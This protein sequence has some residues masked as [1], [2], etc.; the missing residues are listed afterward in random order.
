MNS[1]RKIK[2]EAI[3]FPI[4]DAAVL[5]VATKIASQDTLELSS[6]DL[7]IV[8]ALRRAHPSAGESVEELGR[9]LAQMNQD[10]LQ[11]VVSNAKGILHEML[12]VE[13]ENGDGDTVYAAQFA[14]TNHPGFD[15]SFIDAGS[16]RRW[17]TQLKATDSDSYVREWLTNHPGGEIVVTSEIADRMGIASSGI[18][19]AEL[20]A[21]TSHLVDQLIQADERDVLWDYVPGLTALSAA[22][23]IWE[24]RE[25]LG[26]REITPRQF[27]TMVAKASGKRAA[28]TLGILVLMSI[29]GVNVITGISLLASSLQSSGALSKMDDWLQK[30]STQM[31]ATRDYE[32]AVFVE[33]L[34]IKTALKSAAR[35]RRTQD[36]LRREGED[37]RRSFE[38]SQRQIEE[39]LGIAREEPASKVLDY[40][41]PDHCIPDPDSSGTA[42]GLVERKVIGVQAS[43]GSYL[44]EARAFLQDRENAV[45]F[46]H[47]LEKLVGVEAAIAINR[48]IHQSS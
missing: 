1:P 8:A 48:T 47:A 29:P 43:R 34:A 7:A 33:R 32:D 37:F 18:S 45:L 21:D 6:H 13:L 15:V 46:R 30:K 12:F 5:A 17:E 19:N 31:T 36:L 25:R 23:V 28:R 3:H 20:T 38:A 11:G 10:Q 27:K 4:D 22:M 26:R 40:V 2:A 42:G 9:W 35:D 14:A 44:A 24:L 39:A 41:D 16:G